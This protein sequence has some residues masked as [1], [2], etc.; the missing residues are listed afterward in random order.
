MSCVPMTKK[1]QAKHRPNIGEN[2]EEFLDAVASD[3][4]KF[5]W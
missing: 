5:D 1:F 4:T 3:D 2:K